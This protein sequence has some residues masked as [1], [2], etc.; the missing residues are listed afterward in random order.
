MFFRLPRGR[1]IKDYDVKHK[2]AINAPF[3]ATVEAYAEHAICMMIYYVKGRA[4][5]TLDTL[6]RSQRSAIAMTIEYWPRFC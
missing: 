3:Q 2:F 6:E 4:R 5:E 1:K